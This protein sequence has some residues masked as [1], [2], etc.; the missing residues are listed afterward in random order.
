VTGLRKVLAAIWS[1]VPFIV[2]AFGMLFCIATNRAGGSAAGGVLL[3]AEGIRRCLM[4]LVRRQN[5]L[6]HHQSKLMLTMTAEN[7]ELL[8]SV[9]DVLDRSGIVH[10]ELEEARTALRRARD[11]LAQL[12]QIEQRGAA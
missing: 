3:G 11:R 2:L 4:P 7:T 5:E 6:L 12:E 10:P 8:A 1:V 9:V